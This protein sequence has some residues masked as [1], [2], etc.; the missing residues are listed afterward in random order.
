MAVVRPSAYAIIKD[1][2]GRLAVLRTPMGVFLPGGGIEEGEAAREAV[3]REAREECGLT[4]RL[5]S[6]TAH[7]VQ[8][9]YSEL[10]R[11][12]FEK[13]STFVSA[14]PLLRDRA[15]E[16]DHDLVWATAGSAASLLSHE[17]HRWAV[18]AWRRAS[19]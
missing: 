16:E 8:F 4:L 1:S 7:A 10:E 9:V 6:W 18:D 13:R 14:F 12:H 5:G 11:T 19:T 3:R 15:S 17:S 2:L